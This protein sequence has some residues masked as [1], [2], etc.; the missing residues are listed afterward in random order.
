[1][2]S[3]L[4]HRVGRAAVLGAG[5][6]V[7]G[8]IVCAAPERAHAQGELDDETKKRVLGYVK[9]ANAFYKEERYAESL[10][11]Y[12]EAY[13]LYPNPALLYRMGQAAEK[14]GDLRGAIT[15]YEAM[16]TEAPDNP[17]AGEVK[18]TLATLKDK[19]PP[20]VTITSKPSG[21][22]IRFGSP[23]SP[24]V[25]STPYEGDVEKGT[26][27][28]ILKLDGYETERREI[29][30]AAAAQETIDVR[31]KAAE[32]V[33]D[34]GGT[35][36]D[37]DFP[38]GL[39]GGITAGAGVAVLATGGFFTFQQMSLTDQVNTFDKSG[40]PGAGRLEIARLK[41]EAEGAYQTS[42]GL[43]V[44]GGVLVAAGGA[45]LV[46]DMLG[47]SGEEDDAQSSLDVGFGIL[48]GGG[49]VTFGG[50]F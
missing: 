38:L 12:Q 17:K 29:E 25:G 36:S 40:N 33:E 43:Y 23:N 9:G 5:L 15:Y 13:A 50:T 14:S 46:V 11:L 21:A 22:N 16:L 19:V 45:L 39:V 6:V 42:L 20:R 35:E 7:A 26:L 44:A 31:L 2:V 34:P 24:T 3:M 30:M 1:M 49:A 4:H 10:K 18:A 32:V 37:G 47:G 41:E 27:V 8:A 28:V 48:P